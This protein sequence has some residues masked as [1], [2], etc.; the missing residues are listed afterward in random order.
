MLFTNRDG[1]VLKA[2]AYYADGVLA[3]RQLKELIWP[4]TSVRAMETRLTTLYQHNYVN[5]PTQEQRRT[6]PVPEP[7]LFLG[8]QGTLWLAGQ[9]GITV[10]PPKNTGENQLRILDQRLR[11]AGFRW[12]REPGWSKLGHSIAVVSASGVKVPKTSE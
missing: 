12:L 5:W 11:V 10:K 8:W 6:K 9:Q 3:K 2:I 1:L 4:D 7:I